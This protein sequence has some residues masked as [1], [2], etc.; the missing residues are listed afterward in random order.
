MFGRN[1]SESGTPPSKNSKGAE[2]E[3][4]PNEFQEQGRQTIAMICDVIDSDNK[5]FDSATPPLCK[6]TAAQQ[7]VA[8]VVIGGV[9][10]FNAANLFAYQGQEES[11]NISSFQSQSQSRCGKDIWAMP[12]DEELAQKRQESEPTNPL[13]QMNTSSAH[14]MTLNSTLNLELMSSR[15]LDQDMSQTT[16]INN[17]QNVRFDDFAT[18][19]PHQYESK[20]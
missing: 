16:F 12:L 3:R 8:H 5:E 15:I 4:S 13:P 14:T 19:M 11:T 9:P 2:A 20:I 10:Q 17:I 1:S 18:D 7:Q 6:A